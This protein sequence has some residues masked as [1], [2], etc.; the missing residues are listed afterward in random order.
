MDYHHRERAVGNLELQTV[1][2]FHS[3][4]PEFEMDAQLTRPDMTLLMDVTL[5]AL[6]RRWSSTDWKFSADSNKLLNV[7]CTA[8]PH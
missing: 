1:P 2:K 6:A 3:T 8:A 5:K 7:T 4:L